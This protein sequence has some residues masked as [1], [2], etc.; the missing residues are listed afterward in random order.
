M[1]ILPEFEIKALSECKAGKLVRP[2]S[3][4]GKENFALV[5]D[6]ENNHRR[7]LI[8]LQEDGPV[9]V[10]EDQSDHHHVLEYSGD[11]I[12]ELDQSGPFSAGFGKLYGQVGCMVHD[13][14]RSLLNVRPGDIRWGPGIAQLNCQTFVLEYANIQSPNVAVFGK[15]KMYIGDMQGARERWV[16]VVSFEWS[17]PQEPRA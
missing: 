2:L 8:L 3:H 15:W 5:A 12:L 4:F 17:P 16:K 7:A 1:N 6:I 10:I 13:A 9:F 14:T 11:V